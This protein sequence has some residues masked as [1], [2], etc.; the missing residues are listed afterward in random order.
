MRFSSTP[1]GGFESPEPHAAT[2]PARKRRRAAIIALMIL[3]AGAIVL[4]WSMFSLTPTERRFLG[5]WS[6]PSS[7]DERVL[8][9]HA[10]GTCTR[11]VTEPLGPPETAYWH[12]EDARL[13]IVPRKSRWLQTGGRIRYEATRV[14]YPTM[15]ESLADGFEILSLD[16]DTIRLRG[17]ADEFQLI[18]LDPQPPHPPKPAR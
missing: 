10:D 6:I 12:V 1:A 16:G 11:Q 17:S 7:P 14:F 5:T 9:F 4:A 8:T 2:P 3:L 13:V 15:F 18:R